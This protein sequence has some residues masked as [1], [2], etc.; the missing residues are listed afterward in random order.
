MDMEL[1]NKRGKVRRAKKERDRLRSENSNLKQNQ[2]FASSDLLVVDFEQRKNKLEAMR[3]NL[4]ELKDQHRV[5]LTQA[6]TFEEV[7]GPETNI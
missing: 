3:T 7:M 5:L 6:K 1:T 4:A 2:G